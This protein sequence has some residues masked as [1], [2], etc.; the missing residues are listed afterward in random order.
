M[1]VAASAEESTWRD[2][3]ASLCK[4]LTDQATGAH[5]DW[6]LLLESELRIALDTVKTVRSHS[7]GL[8]SK[9]K[10]KSIIIG[11]G[12]LVGVVCVRYGMIE[13]ILVCCA[14]VRPIV[15]AVGDGVDGA[16]AGHV[17]GPHT[18]PGGGALY[19]LPSLAQR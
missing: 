10:V 15:P 12:P 1:L 16:E 17:H 7:L 9:Y 2:C 13:T 11:V 3:R 6:S 5:A 8:M 18:A 14:G 4:L 19:R